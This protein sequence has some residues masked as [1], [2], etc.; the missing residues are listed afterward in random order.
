MTNKL[1]TK[2]KT[3]DPYGN[4]ITVYRSVDG[5]LAVE[6]SYDLTGGYWWVKV[7][8]INGPGN[9]GALNLPDMACRTLSAIFVAIDNEN[10]KKKLKPKK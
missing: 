10:D 8:T 4:K 2:A 6:L 1:F 7:K 9:D 3:V 5:K